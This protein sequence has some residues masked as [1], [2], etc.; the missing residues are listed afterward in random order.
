[1]FSGALKPGK[2][3]DD[4]L[5]LAAGFSR[6][7]RFRFVVV[8]DGPEAEKI[9]AYPYENVIWMGW[10][11]DI[12]RFL[13]AA[14]RYF[15]L[16]SNEMM[17]MA[18]IEARTLEVPV[19]A[20]PSP[21]NE[22]LINDCGGVS[23]SAAEKLR[24]LIRKKILHIQVLPKLTGVQRVS[25]EILRA[26]PDDEY[27]K[28]ILFGGPVTPQT[29]ECVENFLNAGCKVL[30]MNDLHREIGWH[31]WRAFWRIY[32]LCRR[33]RFDIVHT[34]STKPGIVGRIAARLACVPRVVHTVHGVAFHDYVT[35][36]KRAFYYLAEGIAS[37]FSHRIALVSAHYKKYDRAFG[38]RVRVIYNGIALPDSVAKCSPSA[39]GPISLL[40]VGRLEPAKD[41]LTLLRALAN[42]RDRSPLDFRL[43]VLGDGSLDADCQAFVH[44]H[45]LSD[46]VDFAGWQSNVSRFYTDHP[47]FCLSS[48]HEAFGICLLE[49]GAQGVPAVATR[50]GGVPEVVEDGVTGLLVPPRDP[51]AMARAIERLAAD[52]ELRDQM[53]RAARER[54]RRFSAEKM[55]ESYKALY[56][57]EL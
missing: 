15:F 43:T 47:I 5:T 37:L 45:G 38:R 21:L 26:L 46:M 30:F 32:R 39:A 54:V 2:G 25:F 17:P 44:E 18:L 53:G 41:P 50:V 49:A 12:E 3:L 4:F 22:S 7:N 57:S 20:V 1:M 16:S 42:L 33:E 55:I 36:L 52:P 28:T 34:H 13:L 10:Q 31:D 6:D 48:I 27:E 14:D 40:Y 8:G 35:P 56:N 29:E 11:A 51:A 24:F 19:W 9:H 23:G